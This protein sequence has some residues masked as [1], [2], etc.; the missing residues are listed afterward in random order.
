MGWSA[1]LLVFSCGFATRGA[2]YR[3]AV[4]A[5]AR[6]VAIPALAGTSCTGERVV[7]VGASGYIGRA[8]VHNAARRGY[9]T[10]AV[11]RDLRAARLAQTDGVR[12]VQADVCDQS[13]LQR[14]GG[15]LEP[16]AADVVI[17]CLA[18]RRGTARDAEA[19]DYAATMNCVRAAVA[20]GCRHFVLLSAI[21]VRSAERQEPHALHF[22][23]CKLRV[24]EQLRALA[25]AGVLSHSIVRPTAFFKSVCNQ[26][27]RVA[28]GGRFTYFDLG[29][30]RCIRSNPIS[31]RDLAA[32]LVDTIAEPARRNSVWQ[33]G[34]PNRPLSKIEQGALMAAAAGRP[35]PATVGVPIGVLH[36]VVGALELLARLTR[37][38]PVEDAAEIA[39]ILRYYAT[40]DMVA[41][42]EGE[43]Y[44]SDSLVDFYRTVAAEGREYDPYV[45]IFDSR[46]AVESFGGGASGCSD[47]GRG[48]PTSERRARAVDELARGA[49]VAAAAAGS[50]QN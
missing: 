6:V 4:T 9:D 34:G 49:D 29:G 35:P 3:R 31:E 10:T 12:V 44:G 17:C 24:E 25:A 40:E 36:A 33:I 32:A 26:F 50:A 1:T 38:A 43:V 8:V 48:S 13:S 22:Q 30:G 7:V 21:C 45:A 28:E 27:E 46:E 39:R 19:V 23:D 2:P 42:G 18:S 15:P 37:A 5:R 16:G 14:R 47:A 41:V 20:C 11:V